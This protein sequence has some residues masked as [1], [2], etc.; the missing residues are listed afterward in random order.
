[1]PAL[2]RQVFFVSQG[3][4][5]THQ[6]QLNDQGN[7]F[8]DLSSAMNSFY[9]ATV[10][11]GLQNNVTTFTLSDFGRTLQPSGSGTGI[12]SDHGWGNHQFVMGGSVL[13][14][15]FYGNINPNT[16]SRFPVHQFGGFDDTT[17]SSSGR[18]RWIP[19]TAVDEFGVTLA[20]WLGVS[21]AD[22]PTVFPLIGNF[23][24]N[25]YPGLGFV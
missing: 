9:Q 21:S 22:V 25:P 11:F 13:G 1:M 4:Y 20:K 3:G 6:D 12:G 23:E 17:A 19:S 24:P 7:N 10:E 18:G 8:T 14:G 15:D 16:G 2:T 5:D